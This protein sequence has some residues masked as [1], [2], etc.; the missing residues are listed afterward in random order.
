MSRV[1]FE[2]SMPTV[3]MVGFPLVENR[4]LDLALWYER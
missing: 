3:F 1:D 2:T 4:D